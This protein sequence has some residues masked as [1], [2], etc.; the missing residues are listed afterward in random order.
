LIA[1]I[2]ICILAVPC[3]FLLAFYLALALALLAVAGI[4]RAVY[5]GLGLDKGGW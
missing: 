4:G 3:I 5:C 2:V 1:K